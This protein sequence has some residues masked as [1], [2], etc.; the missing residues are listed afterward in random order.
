MEEYKEIKELLKPRLDIQ[1]S[2]ELRLKV[3]R[4]M[5]R[6]NRKQVV[7]KCVFGG[8]SLSAVAAVLLLVLVPSGMSAKEILAEAINAFGGTEDIEMTVEVR[9]RPVENFRYIDINEDFVTH[10][11]Y[12]SES[13]SLL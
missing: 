5:E 8:I 7:C 4:A 2:D 12:I 1:A 6:K 13:D 10:Q 11:I 9:T 3:I